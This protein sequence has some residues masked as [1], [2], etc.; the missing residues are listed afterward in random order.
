MD[1][2]LGVHCNAKSVVSAF[3]RAVRVLERFKC[4]FCRRAALHVGLLAV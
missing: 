3:Y 4:E 1:I 2:S